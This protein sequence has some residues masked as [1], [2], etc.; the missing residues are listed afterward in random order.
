MVKVSSEGFMQNDKPDGYWKTYYPSAV[1]KSEG[2][3]VNHLLDSTWVFYKETG[4]TLQKVSYVLGK[5][6][7]YTTGYHVSECT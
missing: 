5:R 6:N 3:R 2:N 4:D 1:L 7:G